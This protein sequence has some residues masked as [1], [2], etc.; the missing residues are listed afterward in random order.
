MKGGGREME[1]GTER[2]EDRRRD[3]S[4]LSQ[5]TGERGQGRD[6][7]GLSEGTGIERAG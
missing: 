1:A 5:G 7:S 2:G 3:L 4:D 6:V